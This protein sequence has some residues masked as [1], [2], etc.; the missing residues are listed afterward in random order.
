MI[1]TSIFEDLFGIHLS[2]WEALIAAGC[3]LAGK[4]FQSEAFDP[5]VANRVQI[6][7]NRLEALPSN[8]ARE[9]CLEAIHDQA[10]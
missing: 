7:V 5:E 1:N 8:W 6:A 2:N 10:N 4:Q 3:V 9:L